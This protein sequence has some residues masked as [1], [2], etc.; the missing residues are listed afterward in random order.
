MPRGLSLSALSIRDLRNL[1]RVDVELGPHLNVISGENGQGKTNVLE[2]VYVLATSKSFRTARIGELIAHGAALA[3][4]R[5]EVLEEDD[6][7][8]QSVGLRAGTR[9][10]KVDGRRPRTLAEYAVATPVVVFHPGTLTLSSGGGSE[11]RRMLDRIGLYL[12]PSSI[13]ALERYQGALRGRQRALEQSGVAARELPHFEQLVVE[14][15]RAV[16]ETRREASERLCAAT[17]A[18]FGR[19]AAEGLRLLA[20]YEATAPDDAVA[21]AEELRKRRVEDLRRRSAAIG[22]HRDDVALSLNGHAVRVVASQGQ[23]RAIVLALV[24]G[25][26]EVI[27]EARG[28][29]PVLLLDDVSSELDRERTRA[30]FDVLGE[31]RGQVLLTTTRAELIATRGERCDFVVAGGAVRRAG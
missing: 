1:A 30:L 14:H 23:H 27:S 29:R 4:V 10:V 26:I 12:V 31:Q 11:R 22:P 7:R 16:M 19:I 17:L 3:S 25:E 6:V 18:A 13:G 8:E 2:A 15:G 28:V 20:R 9:S 5:G 24:L 21:Y